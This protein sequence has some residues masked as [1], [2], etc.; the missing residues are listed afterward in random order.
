MGN[1]SS[2]PKTDELVRHFA[3]IESHSQTLMKD[4]TAFRDA[5]ASL[6]SSSTDFA[7][8]FNTIFSPIGGESSYDFE[9][10]FP[11]AKLT[12]QHIGEYTEAFDELKE[13]IRPE[14]ELIES[15]VLA[16]AKE[17][18]EY[19]KKVR[20]TITKREHKLVDFDRHN[21]TYT[22]LREKK[23]KSLSDEK[24][25]F[26]VEQDFEAASSEYEHYN[27]LLQDELPRFFEAATKFITP[28]FHSFYYMQ[29]NIFY[30]MLEKLSAFAQT[31]GYTLTADVAD[32]EGIYLE[33]QG[34]AAER[35]NELSITKRGLSTAQIMAQARIN[36]AAAPSRSK[37]GSISSG[38]RLAGG[39]S[40]FTPPISRQNSS[41]TTDARVLAP[42]PYSPGG[43]AVAAS[44]ASGKRAPPPPPA[45]KPRPS[46]GPKPQTAT[47]LYDFRGES[48]NDLSFQAG[49]VITIIERSESTEDWWVGMLN[50]Q[51][52]SLPAN[53]LGPVN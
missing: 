24:N 35:L 41:S 51:K 37:A 44:A 38:S 8:G 3:V 48:E 22:K 13:T 7:H 9:N 32:V 53:Y 12:I 16:P 42:P 30:V 2:D 50:G 23:E 15:R 43:S 36:N 28:L 33:K 52:G 6:L 4:S 18:S 47:A 21:N 39:S 11:G 46:T 19:V 25:L 49:D 10:K 5:V 29:L 27:N 26:K 17:L 34:D 40:R 20:K 45:L 14:V 31:A 1:K